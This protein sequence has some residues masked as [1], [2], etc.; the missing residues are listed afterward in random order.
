MIWFLIILCFLLI[1]ILSR[2]KG[3]KGSLKIKN[4]IS[5]KDKFMALE[6]PDFEYDDPLKC[7]NYINEIPQ[8]YVANAKYQFDINGRIKNKIYLKAFG[9]KESQ[10]FID[11]EKYLEK[12]KT[13]ERGN[14]LPDENTIIGYDYFTTITVA[15]VHIEHRK[16][17]IIDQL[18]E[19]DLVSL[20]AEP[21]N[22]YDKKAIKVLHNHFPFGY[23][24][25]VDCY[26]IEPLLKKDYR[27][28][29]TDI[30]YG[31]DG[32]IDVEVTIYEKK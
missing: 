6:I 12:F 31:G 3:K 18:S 14:F 8:V 25:A 30:I 29:V 7:L 21:T 2:S 20:K 9:E 23:V 4:A 24:P 5:D 22:K 27:G 10:G 17:H 15:G 11:I 16:S 28:I 1:V 32:Y 19:G 13:F 26:L